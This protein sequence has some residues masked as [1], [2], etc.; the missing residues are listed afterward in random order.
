MPREVQRVAVLGAGAA[1]LSA[2]RYLLVDDHDVTVFERAR[3]SVTSG[4]TTTTIYF[5]GFFNVSGGANISMMDVQPEWMAALVSGEATL[6][7][8]ETMRRRIQE[9]HAVVAQRYPGTP[10]YGLELEPRRYRRQI[11]EE[12]KRG[13]VERKLARFPVGESAGRL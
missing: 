7:D 1:G 5:I 10:R 2:T 12:M 3:R 4:S 6:P 13:S 9:D 11:E 8:V